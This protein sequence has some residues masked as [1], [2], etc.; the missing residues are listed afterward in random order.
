MSSFSP[1]VQIFLLSSPCLQSHHKLYLWW[2]LSFLHLRSE[3]LLKWAFLSSLKGAFEP[4]SPKVM[5][6]QYYY[7]LWGEQDFICVVFWEKCKYQFIMLA[8]SGGW[9]NF[10][11]KVYVEDVGFKNRIKNKVF[12]IWILWI[13]Y[14]RFLSQHLTFKSTSVFNGPERNRLQYFCRESCG[15]KMLYYIREW[16]IK[17]RKH[18]PEAVM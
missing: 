4:L 17:A 16:S 1:S 14:R 8:I 13:N 12:R 18:W 10:L 5:K 9:N 3:E 15:Q 2:E 11:V 7:W 6:W